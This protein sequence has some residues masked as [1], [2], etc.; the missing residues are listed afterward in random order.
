[1]ADDNA[2]AWSI[3]FLEGWISKAAEMAQASNAQ[4]ALDHLKIIEDA[5]NEYRRRCAALQ[6]V[7]TQAKKALEARP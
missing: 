2:V 4:A 7:M 6:D 1:M 5:L 3:G